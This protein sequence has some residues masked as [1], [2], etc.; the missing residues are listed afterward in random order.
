M[1][2]KEN[3]IF[4]LSLLLIMLIMSWAIIEKKSFNMVSNI[5]FDILTEYFGWIYLIAML[6]FVVFI[7]YLAISDYGNIKL[8]KDNSEPEYSTLSWIA[9]LFT[10]GMGVGLVF[11]GIAEPIAHYMNPSYNIEPRTIEAIQFSIKQ[12]FMHWGI[13]PWANYAIVGLSLAYF[14]YRKEEKG[15]ISSVLSPLINKKN[16]AINYNLLIDTLAVFATVA[17]IVTSLGLGVL[18]INSGLQYLYNI[19]N[20]IYTQTFIVVIISIIFIVSAIKGLDKGIKILSN[21]NL[22]LAIFLIFILFLFSPKIEIINNFVNGMG[23]YLGTFIEESLR[24]DIYTNNLWNKTWRIFYWSWWI[25]WAPFVGLFIARISK[26]RTIREFILGVV[27][28][29]SIGS[30]F[31]FSV[32]GT[33]GISFARKGILIIEELEKIVI[34]PEIGLF[35]VLQKYPAGNIL[36]L[37]AITLLVMFFITS[38]DSGTFVLSILTSEG[39]LNPSNLK[40]VFWGCIQAIITI[41]LLIIG[42]LKA[43]QTISIVTAFPFIF[44][45]LGICLSLKKILKEE[46]IKKG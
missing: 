46:K 23:K 10:A 13:H 25:A 22:A 21:L 19:P 18:Q 40:K 12:C 4:L 30:L 36:C 39:N 3:K 2:K 6:I 14:Q 27:I 8:G 37:L 20:N 43:L 11:W 42:G 26:G 24:I 41:L 34:N 16:R 38:A 5:L 45:M 7:I 17:G 29:P 1:R 31:W 9:M 35:L 33:I 28:I 32:F 44:V 15:L